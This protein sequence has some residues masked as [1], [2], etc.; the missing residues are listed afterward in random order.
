MNVAINLLCN[1]VKATLGPKGNN[2]IIDHSTFSPFITND[3]VTIASNIESD[4]EVINTILNI[5]KEASIKT[6]EI[7]GDGTT[8]TLVLLQSIFNEGMKLIDNGIN[9][10]ILKEELNYSLNKL[11]IELKKL[12]IKPSKSDLLNISIT[13]SNSETIGKIIT[14]TFLKVKNINSISI[15]ENNT[16]NTEVLFSKGYS[17]STNLASIYYFKDKSELYI[18][19]PFI[20]LFNMYLDNLEIISN[21]IPIITMK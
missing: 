20:L 21:I 13:S 5:A 17:F 19:E 11:I 4:D 8:T 18:K 2:V 6:N 10:I 16:N 7:V 14:D 1:T 12:S 9:P 15:N 3:G